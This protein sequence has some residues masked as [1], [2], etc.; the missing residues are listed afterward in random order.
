[1]FLVIKKSYIQDILN[2]YE[3]KYVMNLLAL[4]N[5]F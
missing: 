4:F 5:D 2:D 1:M 3:P